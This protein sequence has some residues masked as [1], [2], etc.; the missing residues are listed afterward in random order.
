MCYKKDEKA[1]L[2]SCLTKLDSWLGITSW[3]VP[4]SQCSAFCHAWVDIWP[5]KHRLA[6]PTK[7][8]LCTTSLQVT[9]PNNIKTNVHDSNLNKD[10]NMFSFTLFLLNLSCLRRMV[11]KFYFTCGDVES[12]DVSITHVIQILDKGP[13]TVAMG[14][15]DHLLS[16][17]HT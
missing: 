15:D 12:H 16:L 1:D 11:L 13:Q 3:Y 10:V 5:T 6:Q 8:R 4:G 9:W 17:L 7:H 2:M 14:C